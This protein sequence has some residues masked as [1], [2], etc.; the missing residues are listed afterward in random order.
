MKTG[1]TLTVVTGEEFRQWLTDH[2][3]TKV[4]IW[5][6]FYDKGEGR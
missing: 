3:K 2:H 5:P 1:G 4:E 6:V